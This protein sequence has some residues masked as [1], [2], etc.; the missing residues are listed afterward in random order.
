MILNKHEPEVKNIGHQQSDRK[1]VNGI[2]QT[3]QNLVL[4]IRSPELV[5]MGCLQDNRTSD[6]KILQNG[7][8][9]LMF[10]LGQRIIQL[11]GAGNYVTNDC[12][13]ASID[14]CINCCLLKYNISTS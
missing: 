3:K 7:D 5:Y 9:S 6:G 14:F 8:M 13:L 12:E 4:R 1:F 11:C 2:I 10:L